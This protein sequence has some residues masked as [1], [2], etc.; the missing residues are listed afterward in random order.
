MDN[1]C[2]EV[3]EKQIDRVIKA[4][5]KNNIQGFYAENNCKVSELVKELLNK[6][7]TVSFGGSETLRQCG[8]YELLKSGDYTL[9]D[10]NAQNNTPEDIQRLYRESFSADAYLCSSNA[11]TENG[12]LYNVDGLGNRVAA[13]TFGPKSVIVIAGYNK[14]VSDLNAAIHRV[15][16]LAAPANCL[17]LNKDT[18]CSK[19]GHCVAIDMGKTGMTDGCDSPDRI[20]R[21][22]VVTGKQPKIGRIKVILVGERLGY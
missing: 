17:R 13:I 20:C 9:L 1:N 6:G 21:H 19:C 2:K 7:D 4:L 22:F 16:T 15:K 14:I 3:M 5:E 18:Y 11:I 12:E 10:R 8:I